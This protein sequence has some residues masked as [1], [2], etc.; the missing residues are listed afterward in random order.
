ML[1][2][3]KIIEEVQEVIGKGFKYLLFGDDNI[4]IKKDRLKEIL[5]AIKTFKITFRLNQ[6]ATNLDEE[7]IV[8]AAEAGCT[9]ISFG[10]ESG[11]TK[12]LKL[13]NKRAS[14]ENNKRAIKLTK[15]YGIKAK[16]YFVVNFPGETEE[17]IQET[18]QFARETQSNNWLLSA[19]APLPGSQTFSC[20]E[21]YGINWMSSNW[22][23]YYLVGKDGGFKPCLSSGDAGA[24]RR[25]ATR[26]L[27]LSKNQP[28]LESFA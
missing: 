20:P 21:R 25:N 5:S 10:I 16:A 13:M 2:I 8:L 6:D 17:T 7:V 12:M 22:E 19:F 3:D 28:C 11:S 26:Y 4:A 27:L 18:L 23:D 14:V 24:F 15:A 1:P 9:E